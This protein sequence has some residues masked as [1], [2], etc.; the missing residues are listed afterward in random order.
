MN[1]SILS[2]IVALTF[3]YLTGISQAK[4]LII[5]AT[6]GYLIVG[7]VIWLFTQRLPPQFVANL[8]LIFLGPLTLVMI[9]NVLLTS[10]NGPDA[11]HSAT[12]LLSVIIG[13]ALLGFRLLRGKSKGIF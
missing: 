6:S 2:V 10:I 13:S 9:L 7:G 5:I 3:A 12:L 8:L 11:H 1:K 4:E